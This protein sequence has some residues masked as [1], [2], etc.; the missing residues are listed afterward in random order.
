MPLWPGSPVVHRRPA[1]R[2]PG[3]FA[4]WTGRDY[5]KSLLISGRHP[6]WSNMEME[7]VL[8][9]VPTLVLKHIEAKKPQT[10]QPSS[11]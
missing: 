10:L 1:R 9:E 7:W 5:I 3:A 4:V 11:T 6:T 2:E 8:F